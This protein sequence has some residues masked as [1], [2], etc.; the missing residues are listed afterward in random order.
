M[1]KAQGR[2]SSDVLG[3]MMTNDVMSDEILRVGVL[4]S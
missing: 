2:V 4:L 3:E 1:T